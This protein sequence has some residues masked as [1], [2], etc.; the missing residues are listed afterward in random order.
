MHAWAVSGRAGA[1]ISEA[2]NR[3]VPESGKFVV[4][5]DKTVLGVLSPGLQLLERGPGGEALAGQVGY[6]GIFDG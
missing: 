5:G 2:R 1:Y 6:F 4:D 3:L